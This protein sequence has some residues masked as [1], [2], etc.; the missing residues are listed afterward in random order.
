M[1]YRNTYFLILHN[2]VTFATEYV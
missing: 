1:T 2:A